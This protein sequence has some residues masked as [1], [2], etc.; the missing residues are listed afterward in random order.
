MV[1]IGN[2][3]KKFVEELLLKRSEKELSLY[4][5]V[6]TDAERE[7]LATDNEKADR[8]LALQKEALERKNWK[9][10]QLLQIPLRYREKSFDNFIIHNEVERK[11]I[12]HLMTGKSAIIIGGNGVGKTHLAFASLRFQIEQYVPALY[13]LAFNFFSRIK[14]SFM[15]N[16]TEQ[17]MREYAKVGYLVLDELD[18]AFGSQTEFV[19]LYSLINERYNHLLPTVLITNAETS[20]LAAVIG[21]STLSRVAG[22]GAIIELQG[23]DYRKNQK[24]E[25][26]ADRESGSR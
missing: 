7:R 10:K 22:D 1:A 21:S 16:S 25:P 19:Y 11:A 14:Q 26:S 18:K 12:R 4:G 3:G 8:D 2:L 24:P 20:D 5:R 13:I 17:V 6:L 23:K 15:D 9:E